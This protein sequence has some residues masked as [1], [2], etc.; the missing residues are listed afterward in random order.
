MGKLAGLRKHAEVM[1]RKILDIGSNKQLMLGQI[2]KHS[3]NPAVN[4]GMENLG[5]NLST[6]LIEIVSRINPLGRDGIHTQHTEEFSNEEVEGVEDALLDL[7]ALIFIRYFR[8][9]QLS[10]Y[11]HLKYYMSFQ[12]YRRLLD[13]RHGVICLKQISIIFK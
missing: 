5:D 11:S 4:R 2:K 8:D 3:R 13:I 9:Y 12:F 1:V 7:Y 6:R 10:I